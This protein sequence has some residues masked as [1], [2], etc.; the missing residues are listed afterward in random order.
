VT[1]RQAAQILGVSLKRVTNMRWQ[2]QLKPVTTPH[3]KIGLLD[4]AQVEAL[5]AVREARQLG[6]ERRRVRQ[7]EPSRL[8]LLPIRK[9]SWEDLML[10]AAWTRDNL[11]VTAQYV[12]RLA[13]LGRL[14]W[15]PT[16]RSGGQP[17]RVYRREQIEV[18]ARARAHALSVTEDR[19]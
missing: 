11:G 10:A 5:A 17:T 2:G 12:G 13:A 6:A 7:P 19:A 4:R 8:A 3:R 15:L 16:G 18:I 14:P 1:R 9:A